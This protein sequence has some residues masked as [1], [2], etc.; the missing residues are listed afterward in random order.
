M[1]RAK[2]KRRRVAMI[3]GTRAE[4]GALE[5]VLRAAHECKGLDPKLIV[6][7][8]HLLPKFGR[9]IDQ[10]RDGGWRIDATV[11]MQT[12]RDEPG[13]EALAVARGIAGI[14]KAITRLDGDIVVVLGD[15]I[16]AF[17]G[18]AAATCGR[19]VLAHIHGG[20][21]ALGDV[22][23]ALRNAITRL[24]HVHLV[25]SKDAADRLRRM[26]EAPSRIHRVGAP[27]LDDIRRFRQAERAN[28]RRS[29]RR[30]RELLGLLA[31]TPF[32]VVVHHP[33]GRSA[34]LEA[35]TCRQIVAA[36]EQCELAGVAI[37]P[38]SDPGHQGIID[39]LSGL[40]RHPRWRIFRSLPRE[41]YLRLLSRSTV[42]VGNSS[43]G[44]IE[45]ASLGTNAVNIGPRQSGRLR[46]GSS[47]ID[48]GETRQA[49]VRAIRQAIRRPKPATGRSVYGNGTSGQRI[50]EVL[51]NLKITPSLLQ[52]QLMY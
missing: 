37:F 47:V 18:A 6:T 11:P 10:I 8:M 16:E 50:V 5:T 40:K 24:A 36:V 49:I 42:L 1:T 31:E 43:S 41:D 27:G 51:E 32:A 52:K 28:R 19:R 46:C 2:A 48:A 23:D 13:A 25:A 14:A 45:S 44:I 15:R 33:R 4:F 12:G 17:A 29:D 7:G 26:G 39:V 21:R 38:N 34:R 35:A 9:T 30:L 3:T 20:D 22:D